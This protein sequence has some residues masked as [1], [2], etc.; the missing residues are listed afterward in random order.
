MNAWREDWSNAAPFGPGPSPV[1]RRRDLDGPD[2][3][4]MGCE[5]SNV[6]TWWLE[7]GS[8]VIA[9]PSGTEP[10]V[11]VYLE[12]RADVGESGL[13]SART[14]AASRLAAIRAGVEATI[15]AVK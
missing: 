4:A 13:E 9:R 5:R 8:R 14:D 1:T 2:A 7:D 6:L 15:A 12:T 11:K 3:E 10:K